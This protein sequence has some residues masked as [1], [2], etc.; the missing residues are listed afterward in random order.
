MIGG[1]IETAP[2]DAAGG[3]LS[4][5]APPAW[6]RA[7]DAVQYE[8]SALVGRHRSPGLRA[9]RLDDRPLAPSRCQMP[10]VRGKC[11]VCGGTRNLDWAT[12]LNWDASKVKPNVRCSRE[13]GGCVGI[14][15]WYFRGSKSE[16]AQ[17]EKI[18]REEQATHDREQRRL[19]EEAATIFVGFPEQRR[20]QEEAAPVAETG[21]Q[22][23]D[24]P[25]R[26]YMR[27]CGNSGESIYDTTDDSGASI[28]DMS[29]RYYSGASIYDM[30]T[31]DSGASTSGEYI[32][33][34]I[35]D[36]TGATEEACCTALVVAHN[37]AN[38]AAELI[39]TG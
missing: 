19:Q 13:G 26:G 18:D 24:A 17:R 9:P 1:A 27:M 37:D 33:R 30:I 11:N 35:H 2:D 22:W 31:S 5:P 14:M 20:L 23:V 34:R 3:P 36:I 8:I 10:I 25:D 39:L 16:W 38:L 12:E 28:Y 32:W 29:A 7:R 21:I 4:A 6:G 15:Q